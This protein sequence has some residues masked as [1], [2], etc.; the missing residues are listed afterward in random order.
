V[1]GLTARPDTGAEAIVTMIRARRFVN[2]LIVGHNKLGDE[3]CCHLFDFLN[4][5]DGQRYDIEEISLNSNC[6]GDEGLLSISKYLSNNGQLRELFL[7][8]VRR[9]HFD[10]Y[11]TRVH[12]LLIECVHWKTRRY[13]C[14]DGCYQ[15]IAT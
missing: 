9:Q 8:N 7:Q 3:G 14:I 12:G 2:R 5:K 10:S 1:L 6:I 13:Q 11:S 15:L 4:S